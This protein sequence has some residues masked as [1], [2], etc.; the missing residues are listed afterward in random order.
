[1]FTKAVHLELLL[2]LTSNALI[3]TLKRF[4]APRGKSRIISCDNAFNF[5]RVETS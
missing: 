1:M 2:D 3:A 4:F 5:V